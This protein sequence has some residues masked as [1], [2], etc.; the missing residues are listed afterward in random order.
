MGGAANALPLR[1][2]I[3]FRVT[4]RAFVP[5]RDKQFYLLAAHRQPLAENVAAHFIETFSQPDDL[6]VD[7]FVAS[8]AVV[9][10]ALQRGRRIIA[11]DSNP[12][13]AWATKVQATLPQ[14]RDVHAALARLGETRKE[15]E[16]L[17]AALEKLYA[18]QCAQ[19]GNGVS[20]DYFVWRRDGG[21]TLL[22]EKMYTCAQCGTRRDDATEADRQRAQDAAPRGLSYHV[23]VQRLLADDL[24]N[25]SLIKRLLELYTPRN[26]NALAAIT[27]KLDVEFREDASRNTLAVMLLHALD[28]GTSLYASPDAFPT[29]EIPDE[30]VEINVWRALEVAARGLSE[31]A[32]ALRL[33]ATPAHV[34]KSKTPVAFI[35]QGGARVL[36]EQLMSAN[37]ALFLSS[38]ARLD[39]AFWELSFL[40]TRWL[41][42]KNAATPLEIFL[43][44]DNQR[45]GWYGK[46]LTNALEDTTKLARENTKLVIAFP[47]GSH[48]MIEALM[49][50]A[51]PLFALQDFA[52]R[53]ARGA[54]HSTEW[55]ALRG[56]YQAVW[57]REQIT[58]AAEATLKIGTKIRVESLRAARAIL[59]ARHEPLFYSW[60]HH[61]ALAKLAR[62]N[63]L[64]QAL[65]AK[66]DKGD[67]A[68]Q[69]LRHRMEEGFREGY[70]EDIDHWQGEGRVLWE[71][72]AERG[73]KTDDGWQTADQRLGLAIR[74]EN[75]ARE[76]LATRQKIAANEFEDEMLQR[77]SGLLTPEIELVEICARAYAVLVE[78][79]WH[80]RNQDAAEFLD[81]ARA[82]A[83]A[84]GARLGFQ[85]IERAEP[86]DLIWRLEKTIPASASGALREEKIFEDAYAFQFRARAEFDELEKLRALPLRGL[87]VIPEMQIEI[88]RERL[89]REPRWRKKLERAGWDFLRVPMMEILS[90]EDLP[91]RPE[92]QLALGLEPALAQGQ[93]QLELF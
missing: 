87:V 16:T 91:T 6:V 67:N 61:A 8:D 20:V 76:I 14:A 62:E 39:P 69:F 60:L 90:R 18:S 37:A 81:H 83:R 75:W 11:S 2:D 36:V 44:S 93:E 51:S 30:F 21:K 57:Q 17:R 59:D 9:R 23:L 42:G 31:R 28:V 79:E 72:R 77:L 82:L 3:L 56:D 7:P 88:T 80:W 35:G 19:C 85:I 53:P 73:E 71:R 27:Q 74:V 40:W 32:P 45:W 89:R 41:L 22:A 15:G 54:T 25:A 78:G 1:C 47:S 50:A 64:A 24:A 10:A 92:F 34:L 52:F 38:P 70:A 58:V 48:A 84:L 5:N 33:A 65:A 68:F 29:R 4:E 49:L 26:L 63:V 13:V 66:Y 86:F 43:S 12:L 46:A 55:G